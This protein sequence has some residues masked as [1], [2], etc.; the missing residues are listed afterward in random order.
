VVKPTEELEHFHP[1]TRRAWRKWLAKHHA[2][3]PGVWLVLDK[4]A[5]GHQ[6]LA[7]DSVVEE[8]LCFGWI[9][10][11]A[12]TIDDDQFRVLYKPRNPKSGWSAINKQRVS[13]LIAAGLMAPAGLAKIAEAKRNGAWSSLD[14]AESLT[15][16]DDLGAALRANK[17]AAAN[18]DTF[19]PSSKKLILTWIASAKRPETRAKRIAETVTL[20]AK[21]IR[22]N[23]YRQ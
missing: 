18:Y 7:Y 1:A 12:L 9:D 17:R 16:P 15:V 2:T 8:A 21:G 20:A 14:A 10:G 4:A 6:K 22:A 23:H 13:R 11:K 5:S 19:A 3:R